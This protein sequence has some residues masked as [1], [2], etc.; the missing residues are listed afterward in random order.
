MKHIEDISA[1]VDLLLSSKTF[2][3]LILEG[4]PGWGKSSA[5]AS[6]FG[7]RQISFVSL[8]SYTTPMRLFQIISENEN[9]I[10]VLDDCAGLFGDSVAMS[11][12][13]AATWPSSVGEGT[14]AVAWNSSSDKVS[15]RVSNFAG[16][17][18][19]LANCIPAGSDTAAFIS[20]SLHYCIAPST[21]DMEVMIRQVARSGTFLNSEQAIQ[22]ADY[23]IQVGKETDFRGVN[24]RTLQLGYELASTGREDWATL[25]RRILPSPDCTKLAF[26][27]AS[28]LGSVE[29]QFREFHRATGLS[30]RTFFNYRARAALGSNA[31]S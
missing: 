10:L 7:E 28:N 23:L 5:V 3:S 30:R 27:S 20:R 14:R 9:A 18:V 21:N 1:L 4:A 22:V 16:K 6:I 2:H 12:L 29:E 17:I 11:L 13:K 24:L 26:M 19:L 25:F 31:E 8:G 15:K